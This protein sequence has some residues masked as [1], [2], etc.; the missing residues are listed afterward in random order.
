MADI[1]QD[2]KPGPQSGYREQP[3]PRGQPG[4]DQRGDGRQV[5]EDADA[6]GGDQPDNREPG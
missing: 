1:R 3:D 5:A 2:H 4:Q 6:E